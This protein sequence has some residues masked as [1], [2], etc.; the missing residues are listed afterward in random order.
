MK[1]TILISTTLLIAILFLVA[2]CRKGNAPASGGSWVFKS[3][4]YNASFCSYVLG[5]LTASTENSTPIG[6]MAFYFYDSFSNNTI[7]NN[8]SIHESR[9]SV[10]STFP[11]KLHSYIVTNT[12]PP[13][14]GYVYVQLT[15]TSTLYNY[16]VTTSSQNVSVTVTVASN[17][18]VKV[19]LPPVQMTNK[20]IS[21]YPLYTDSSLVSGTITQTQ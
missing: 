13:D 20:E 11:P 5:A 3:T 10:S 16:V 7:A 15:D 6:S 19:T 9:D 21:T 17:G 18:F 12:F 2:S 1:K 4:T 14:S 8:F